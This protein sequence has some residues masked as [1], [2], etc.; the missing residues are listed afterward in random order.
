[1]NNIFSWH[2]TTHTIQHH[3]CKI[4]PLVINRKELNGGV[5]NSLYMLP[6]IY[7]SGHLT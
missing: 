1:M 7:D 6:E 3:T 5:P 2:F 4:I